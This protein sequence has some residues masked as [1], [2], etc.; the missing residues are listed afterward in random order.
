MRLELYTSAFCGACHAARG[1]VAEAVGLVPALEASEKDVAFSPDEAEARGIEATPTILLTDD[2]GA[3]LFRS[4]GV[5]TVPQLLT[6]VARHL[7]GS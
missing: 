4:A 2:D 7:P 5:P 3:E 6:A 1:A